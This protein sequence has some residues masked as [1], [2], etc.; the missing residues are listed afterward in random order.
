[1]ADVLHGYG[2]RTP[3]TVMPTGIDLAEFSGGDGARFRERHGIGAAQPTLVTV[4]RLSM[5][6]NIAFLFEV[7]HKLVGEFPSLLFI[8]AGEGADAERLKRRTAELGLGG[9]VRFFGNL[10]RR[11]VLLDGYRAGDVFVFASPTETQGLVLIEAMALGV[12][13]VSTAVMGTA[14][15][16]AHAHNARVSAEDCR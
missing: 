1:M 3:A 8:I 10:D 6:K 4:S 11:T 5:E 7:V 9:N 15:V 14:T 16:L 2:V 12:P 13:I